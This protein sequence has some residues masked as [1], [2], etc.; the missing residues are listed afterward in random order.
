MLSVVT[1]SVA[2]PEPVTEPGLMV[3]ALAGLLGHPL[4]LKLTV[5]AN[6]FN[7]V[8][9]TVEGELWPWVSVNELGEA[10]I[11]K[12]GVEVPLHPEKLKEAIRVLQALP[13][14]GWYSVVNQ[15]V[16]SS[17]GSMAILL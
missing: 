10:A 16:Q 3:Q 17:T 8:T 13:L 11:E 14:V 5:P 2:V 1:V 6:P 15:N 7:A 9:V 4:K 12:S